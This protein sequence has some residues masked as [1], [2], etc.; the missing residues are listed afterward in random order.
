MSSSESIYSDTRPSERSN[1]IKRHRNPILTCPSERPQVQRQ[2]TDNLLD[3]YHSPHAGQS[4]TN[5]AHSTPARPL[6]PRAQGSVSSYYSTD[7]NGTDTSRHAS[8]YQ[9]SNA[10]ETT[11]AQQSFTP[12]PSPSQSVEQSDHKS[13]LPSSSKPA[14]QTSSFA[15]G[16][17][18]TAN[19]LPVAPLQ[20]QSR[21][22]S[23][24]SHLES[25]P[26]RP[27]EY[28]L[29]KN[30]PITEPDSDYVASPES[31]TETKLSPNPADIPKTNSLVAQVTMTTDPIRT[32][33]RTPMH[34]NA[35]SADQHYE[36]DIYSA[37]GSPPPPPRHIKPPTAGLAPPPR[38]PRLHSPAGRRLQTSDTNLSIPSSPLKLV[39]Q[40]PATSSSTSPC[41]DIARIPSPSPSKVNDYQTLAETSTPLLENCLS[42]VEPAD[43][44]GLSF[45]TTVS[46]SVPLTTT[47]Q[48]EPSNSPYQVVLHSREGAITHN[49]EDILIQDLQGSA[50]ERQEC[51][52][53]Q[54][55]SPKVDTIVGSSPELPAVPE[56]H[57]NSFVD[58]SKLFRRTLLLTMKVIII[59]VFR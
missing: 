44:S 18:G 19:T 37:P 5:R 38:P 28:A 46:Q 50:V 21:P 11:P 29:H 20:T 40:P 52:Q 25:K 8:I 12:S 17:A 14:N 24:I 35:S 32:S 10:H 54:L 41:S 57:L 34:R 27:D 4:Y 59:L 15:S 56:S 58:T 26:T 22:G 2:S 53:E 33:S 7:G 51:F 45:S 23:S 42:E 31:S 16:D 36:P 6:G 47:I 9:A 3:Y 1:L 48:S 49:H 39:G 13:I 30:L 55:N 43:S